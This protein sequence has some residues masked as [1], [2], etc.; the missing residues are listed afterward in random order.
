MFGKTLD[1]VVAVLLV[2]GGLNWGLIGF[3]EFDLVNF[4]FGTV[5]YL[6]RIVY[7][8]VGCCALY[9]GFQWRAIPRRWGCEV[10]GFL[11]S[12]TR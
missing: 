11:G 7:A 10:P 3:L 2:I 1:V 9:R 8:I 12:V 4:I 6:S 5:P